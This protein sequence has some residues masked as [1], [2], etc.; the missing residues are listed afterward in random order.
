M[1]RIRWPVEH[2]P[3]AAGAKR[4]T[5]FRCGPGLRPDTRGRL[6]CLFRLPRPCR[7]RPTQYELR[8]SSFC[9]ASITSALCKSLPTRTTNLPEYS[10]PAVPS[11]HRPL[12][13]CESIHLRLGTVG[14][15][16]LPHPHHAHHRAS[17]RDKF[18]RIIGRPKRPSDP[19]RHLVRWLHDQRG[20]RSY[21]AF[22]PRH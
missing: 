3:A 20:G 7:N 14:D 4:R 22:G 8:L 18:R 19:H 21:P 15:R 17:A 5:P 2:L 13:K 6:F 1:G 12:R 9:M 10:F 11:G 16:L